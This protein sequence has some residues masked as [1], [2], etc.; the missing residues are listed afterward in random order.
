MI[1]L[2][3]SPLHGVGRIV[4]SVSSTLTAADE[5]TFLYFVKP[6]PHCLAVFCDSL[7]TV[8]ENGEI[9][10]QSHFSAT[11]WTGYKFVTVDCTSCFSEMTPSHLS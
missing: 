1:L 10:R 8:A 3:K 2:Q 7:T 4:V 5:A 11:V 9:R 6:C